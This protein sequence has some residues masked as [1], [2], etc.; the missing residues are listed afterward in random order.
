MVDARGLWEDVGSQRG[1]S[2]WIS[3]QIERF[4]L[5][6]HKDYERVIPTSDQKSPM[7]MNVYRENQDILGEN[8]GF[9]PTFWPK[10]TV[11]H[12]C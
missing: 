4:K 5:V 1:F 10:I 8:K 3:H 6:E 7:N 12:Q 11:Q 9:A 2:N